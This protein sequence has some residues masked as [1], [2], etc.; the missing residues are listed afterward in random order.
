MCGPLG[1]A[2]GVAIGAGGLAMQ[3]IGAKQR[4]DAEN[5]SAE[6]SARM[7][8]YNASISQ[9]NVQ[10]AQA[11]AQDAEARGRVAE[12]QH[13]QRVSQLK[14]TQRAGFAA[15]GVLVDSGSTQD[16][17]EDT[18]VFGELDA[19]TI[20]HNAATEAFGERMQAANFQDQ[21]QQLNM[22]ADM[23]RRQKRNPWLSAGTTLLTG[24]SQLLRGMI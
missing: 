20:R 18:A 11:R 6:F 9:K 4:V 22:Q 16:V 19:L 13:R 8:E 1:S 21:S 10:L 12:K 24:G 5:Q 2:L 23:T 15:S 3:T 17:L 14:G 7:N